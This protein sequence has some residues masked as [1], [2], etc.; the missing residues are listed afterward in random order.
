MTERRKLILV[1]ARKARDFGI[2]TYIRG[3]LGGLAGLDRFDLQALVLPGD[4]AL[5][6]AGVTTTACAAAHYSFGEL[7]AVRRAISAVEAGSLPCPALRRAALPAARDG[8]HD[9]RPHAPLPARARRAREARVRALD[10][11]PRAAALRAS[12]RGVGGDEERNSCFR[13]LSGPQGRGDSKWSGREILLRRGREECRRA[14]SGRGAFSL[15]PFKESSSDLLLIFSFSATTSR[16]RTSTGCSRAWPRVRA[17]H[18][19]LSLV[20]AGVE[21]GRTLPEG[22]KAV[23]FVP[24]EDVPRPSRRRPRAR[25]ALLRGGL[26]TAGPRGAGGGHARRVL[27]PPRPPRGRGRRGGVLR[28]ARRRFDGRGHSRGF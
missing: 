1:D 5:L 19:A 17:A 27:G 21:P 9:P 23:G 25:S 20:L 22:A 26:R 28:S 11:R 8:R 13:T 14:S 16:T 6:P 3:L 24:D 7:V 4:E 10:D 15:P 18:P 2:G 12:H